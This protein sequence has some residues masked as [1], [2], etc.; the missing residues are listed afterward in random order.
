MVKMNRRSV[1]LFLATSACAAVMAA[2]YEIKKEVPYRHAADIAGDA[3]AH[4]KCVLDIY[5]P[6]SE[7]G[8]PVIIWFHGGGLTSG[9]K[10]IPGEIRNQG[11]CIV[12][13][14]YR[15]S[16]K[17]PATVCIEDATAAVAW[18]FKNIDQYGGD[19]EK[20][21][22]SGHSAGGYLAS[23]VGLDKS[24][25]KK[26]GVDA[27]QIAGLIPFSGHTITHFTVRGERGIPGHQPIVDEFAPLYHVRAD[28]PP[29]LLI[30]GDRELELL[31]RY[32]ENAY[33]MRMMRVAGHKD[34]RVMELDGY[35]HGMER[36]AYP[37]L[38][39]EVRRVLN[40]D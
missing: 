14:A 21:F 1:L 18:V 5:H 26:H 40:Q 3:Y 37:L 33:M 7:K 8:V 22:I 15:L 32:E 24:Y 39:N 20:I 36:P 10:Y 30:T 38:I 25:L 11:M 23:M 19:P 17:V 12:A 4:E 2:E 29:L 6:V 9:K 28:A 31:G 34:T 35:N 27:N 13:P 16:P